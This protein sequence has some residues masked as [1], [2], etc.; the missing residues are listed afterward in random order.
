[1]LQHKNHRTCRGEGSVSNTILTKLKTAWIDWKKIPHLCVNCNYMDHILVTCFINC[2][3]SINV[4]QE[5]QIVSITN[6]ILDPYR[7]F[8]FY[9]EWITS[10]KRR[11]YR[12]V[13][14]RRIFQGL[15]WLVAK[16]SHGWKH[17]LLC[18]CMGSKVKYFYQ[19]AFVTSRFLCFIESGSN[20]RMVL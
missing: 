20:A 18:K 14:Q 1:M 5:S 13:S 7:C 15:W 19:Q 16:C 4:N 11:V 9:P 17:S 12:C 8:P 2:M 6:L 3:T 10:E